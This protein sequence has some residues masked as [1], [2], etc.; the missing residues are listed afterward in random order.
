MGEPIYPIIRCPEG[1]LFDEAALL[2]LQ[3]EVV[4]CS[5]IHRPTSMSITGP[6]DLLISSE[7]PSTAPSWHPVA[8]SAPAFQ[9]SAVPTLDVPDAPTGFSEIPT[10]LDT[11]RPSQSPLKQSLSPSTQPIKAPSPPP[12]ALHTEA[13]ILI[14]SVT[15]EPTNTVLE[16]L[17]EYTGALPWNGCMGYYYCIDSMPQL[18]I[19]SCEA[20]KLFDIASSAC[21]DASIVD[22]AQI[23]EP[24]TGTPNLV[25]TIPT[26]SPIDHRSKISTAQPSI[27]SEFST[28]SSNI[29]P[30]F[31][32]RP[33]SMTPS[34]T[35]E[36]SVADTSQEG[37]APYDWST[38][39]DMSSIEYVPNSGLPQDFSFD[40]PFIT[41][42]L[43]IK[44]YPDDVG[45]KL[46]W[47]DGAMIVEKPIGAYSNLEP[48]SV[49]FEF[50]PIQPSMSRSAAGH[51][52]EWTIMNVRGMGLNGGYWKMYSAA[53]NEKTLLATGVDFGYTDKVWLT[54]SNEGHIS[55]RGD[56]VWSHQPPD[57]VP[58][59]PTIV[60][61]GPNNQGTTNVQN[62]GGE[63]LHPNEVQNPQPRYQ[64]RTLLTPV[65]ASVAVV[66]LFAGI[67]FLFL[68]FRKN[69]HTCGEESEFFD[70]WN[71]EEPPEE[72]FFDDV[73]ES[74]QDQCNHMYFD[75]HSDSIDPA[76]LFDGYEANADTDISPDKLSEENKNKFN[77]DLNLG[78]DE[79]Q[80]DS[81]SHQSVDR[82][83]EAVGMDASVRTQSPDLLYHVPD[84]DEYFG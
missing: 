65:L 2:C 35:F 15:H 72:D 18:P 3:S 23:S 62:V 82:F 19:I 11:T 4:S 83:D 73:P 58:P 63:L 16:C 30:E 17:D 69:A 50:I 40:G 54:V 39:S 1:T 14:A 55:L 61:E 5:E 24:S 41:V 37:N 80:N 43:L 78:P 51:A 32:D 66:A 67:C 76:G 60:D 28:S 44:D 36:H 33:A 13:P 56:S 52:L 29:T 12:A 49:V 38:T 59:A 27:E 53:P 81:L 71:I 20:G 7:N 48:N 57:S 42:E 26:K 34:E 68:A 8:A 46:L 22:C 47:L 75:D 9:L 70:K 25:T 77:H 31:D 10:L 79:D 64:N 21:L 74:E 6:P 45:W 84:V